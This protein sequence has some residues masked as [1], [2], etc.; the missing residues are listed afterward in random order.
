MEKALQTPQ[1]TTN[2]EDSPSPFGFPCP[3]PV[4]SCTSLIEDLLAADEPVVGNAKRPVPISNVA[5]PA[6]KLTAFPPDRV[7]PAAPAVS[8][9]P[10]TITTEEDST[11]TS[12][13][14]ISISDDGNVGGGVV[15]SGIVLEPMSKIPDGWRLTNVPFTV[16]AGPPAEMMVLAMGNAEG[17]GVKV[18]PATV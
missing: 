9:F 11:L 14:S 1:T 16:A 4:K 6:S 18:W 5:P 15:K 13:P 8:V 17:F 10:S 2:K 12:N 3:P 7:T